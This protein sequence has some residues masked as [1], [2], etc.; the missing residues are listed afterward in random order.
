LPISILIR[1]FSGTGLTLYLSDR[2]GR[3][4]LLLLSGFGMAAAMAILGTSF[5]LSN[6][7]LCQNNNNNHTSDFL[8]QNNNILDLL[9]LNNTHKNL[10]SELLLQNN[11]SNN[12][13]LISELLLQNNCSNNNNLTSELLLQNNSNSNN[14]TS[15]FLL[16]LPLMGMCLFF[17]AYA[18]GFNSVILILLGELYAPGRFSK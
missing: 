6:N 15:V 4:I 12:N 13:N 17:F 1:K 3:K 10:T 9:P 18:I 2:I 7:K 8:L 11:S 5:I 16:Y 14:N